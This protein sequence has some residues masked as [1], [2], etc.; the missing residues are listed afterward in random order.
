MLLTSGIL[1]RAADLIDRGWTRGSYA[2]TDKGTPVSWVN[3]LATCF[4]AEGAVFLAVYEKRRDLS[5][6]ELERT[7]DRELQDIF[8]QYFN[9]TT[10]IDYNDKAK[11]SREISEKLRFLAEKLREKEASA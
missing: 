6:V 8:R 1:D 3:P 11:S 5:L 10:I 7:A 2:R 9:T 4:C